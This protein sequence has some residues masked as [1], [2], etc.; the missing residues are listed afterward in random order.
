MLL[1]LRSPSF[2]DENA[3]WAWTASSA[4]GDAHLVFDDGGRGLRAMTE[5]L[6]A[7]LPTSQVDLIELAGQFSLGV[8]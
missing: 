5:V 8:R 6:G 7:L 2:D 1:H 4:D 3:N